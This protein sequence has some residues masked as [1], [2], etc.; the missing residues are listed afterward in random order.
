M[1]KLK[2]EIASLFIVKATIIRDIIK[3][4]YTLAKT[5]EWELRHTP[6]SF[7]RA[8]KDSY[9]TKYMKVTLCELKFH[10]GI[11][12]HMQFGYD[13][14]TY[15]KLFLIIDKDG[16]YSVNML[17]ASVNNLILTRECILELLIDLIN[18]RHYDYITPVL[19]KDHAILIYDKPL[20]NSIESNKYSDRNYNKLKCNK[21]KYVCE[22]KEMDA[23]IYHD[24]KAAYVKNGNVFIGEI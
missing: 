18:N 7:R 11:R 22:D 20:L 16:D 24:L 13:G 17:S 2:V 15:N 9:K 3:D 19:E 6:A 10:N 4:V 8:K 14:D 21:T 23:I 5:I 12:M 1:E